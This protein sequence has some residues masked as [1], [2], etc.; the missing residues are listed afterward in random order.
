MGDAPAGR[1]EALLARATLEGAACRLNRDAVTSPARCARALDAL[2]DFHRR[3]DDDA[4]HHWLRVE[5]A[6]TEVLVRMELVAQAA[7]SGLPR[8]T[9]HLDEGRAICTRAEPWLPYA[10][11]NGPELFQDC[12]RLAGT[13]EAVDDYLRWSKLLVEDDLA[14]GTLAKTTLGHLYGGGGSGCEGTI[15]EKRRGEWQVR[16]SAWCVALGHAARGCRDLAWNAAIE[17][18]VAEPSRPWTALDVALARP[19]ATAVCVR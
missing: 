15:V 14:D 9:E 18:R 6:W 12:L 8:P 5:A 4:E 17:G 3:L 7:S 1:P 16:G 10:P 11:V 13:A 19:D 2:E